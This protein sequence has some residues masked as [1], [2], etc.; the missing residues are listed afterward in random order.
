M[1]T[2][3]LKSYGAACKDIGLKTERR[4]YKELNIWAENPHLPTRRRERIMKRFK[5]PGHVQ[6]FLT[7][8]EQVAN[9]FHFP[10]NRLSANAHRTA[11]A[12]AFAAWCK[13]STA[14]LAARTPRPSKSASLRNPRRYLD[15]AFQSP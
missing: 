6:R 2:D 15:D 4:Q 5:S 13:I 11:R 14:R 1:I 10:R 3:M 9:L 8:Q 7:I 12:E